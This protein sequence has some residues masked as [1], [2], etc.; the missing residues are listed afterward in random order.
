[1]TRSSPAV[2]GGKVYI[3]DERGHMVCYSAKNGKVLWRKPLGDHISTCPVVLGDS[4]V[5]ASEDGKIAAIMPSGSV[6]WRRDLKTRI[7]GQPIPTREQLIV[8]TDNGLYVLKSDD[9]KD[10]ERFVP[11]RKAG[12]VYTALPYK[13][14]LCL[15]RGRPSV[16]RA[17]GRN[18]VNYGGT[19][20]IWG[21]EEEPEMS[22]T[23][24]KGTGGSK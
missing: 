2:R 5:Y 12:K 10:D 19:V 11:P 8:P 18:F 20:E 22:E 3:G 4:V 14:F 24:E 16:Y 23:R 13:G 21:P 7:S 9:G 15:L 17:G 6:R 1:F